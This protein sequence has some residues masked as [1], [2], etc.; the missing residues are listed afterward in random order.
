MTAARLD[1]ASYADDE[2]GVGLD[3]PRAP[4][5]LHARRGPAGYADGAPPEGWG[6]VA[7]PVDAGALDLGSLLIPASDSHGESATI[8]IRM[9]P[10][11]WQAFEAAVLGA[12]LGLT[13]AQAG[14]HALAAE[15]R[16]LAQVTRELH[17]ADSPLT[18]PPALAYLTFLDGLANLS[19][20]HL[21]RRSLLEEFRALE[22]DC[23]YYEGHGLMEMRDLSVREVSDHVRRALQAEA[24]AEGSGGA[25]ARLAG[26]EFR[27]R[28]ADRWE[29]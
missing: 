1:P 11:L 6:R 23:A 13:A 5:S 9:P 20:N 12:G 28:F 17:R 3:G 19:R 14:R 10:A 18:P 24:E 25:W 16:W 29:E 21:T 8:A 2:E 7:A 27:R 26:F 4:L 15:A 22:E